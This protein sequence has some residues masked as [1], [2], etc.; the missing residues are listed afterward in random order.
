[1]LSA[2]VRPSTGPK[3]R[4]P[5]DGAWQMA[6]GGTQTFTD[7]DGYAAAIGATHLNLTITGAGFQG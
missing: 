6:D 1:M 7:P 5:A 2:T 3:N 4:P